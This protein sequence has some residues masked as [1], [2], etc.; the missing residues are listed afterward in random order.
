M[1]KAGIKKKAVAESE[2]ERIQD[3]CREILSLVKILL[4][5]VGFKAHTHTHTN[6]PKHTILSSNTA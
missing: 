6:H 3:L 4:E 5:E 2:R 1:S